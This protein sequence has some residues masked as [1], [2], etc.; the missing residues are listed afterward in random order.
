MSVG[1]L[2]LLD[3]LDVFK[4]GFFEYSRYGNETRTVE[5][6]IDDACAAVG[7][8]GSEHGFLFDPFDKLSQDLVLDIL[9]RAR[10]QSRVEIDDLNVVENVCA[11]DQSQSFGCRRFGDLATVRA[12][13][14]VTVIFCGVVGRRHHNAR[15]RAQTTHG[16]R[17][18][19]RWH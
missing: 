12:V 4:A 2:L 18:A 8:C 16:V 7:F 11:F 13:H 19:R 14:L 17:Q 10:F 5:R 3:D 1:K 15:S 9:D 6:R